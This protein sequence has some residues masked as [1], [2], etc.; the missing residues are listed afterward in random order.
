MVA[1]VPALLGFVQPVVVRVLRLEDTR[2]DAH[3]PGDAVAV[4]QQFVRGQ[5]TGQAA[6]A[7]GDRMDGQEVQ[8]QG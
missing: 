6:V 1:L 5:Q 2:F 7:V 8:D 4:G 3:I